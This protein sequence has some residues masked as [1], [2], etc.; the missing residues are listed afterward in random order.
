MHVRCGVKGVAQGR[1]AELAHVA[2]L[3][4][5]EV[6]AQVVLAVAVQLLGHPL[7]VQLVAERDLLEPAVRPVLVRRHAQVVVLLVAQQRPVVAFRAVRLA[8]EQRH[9]ALLL[10]AEGVLRAAHVAVEGGIVGDQRAL[11]RG[12]GAP[13]V[14]DGRPLVAEHP[15]EP[16]AVLGHQAQAGFHDLAFAIARHGAA[17]RGAGLGFQGLGRAGPEQLAQVGGVDHALAV[18]PVH[19][20]GIPAAQRRGEGPAGV[21]F[22]TI[23][24]GNGGIAAEAGVE[25][26]HLAQFHLGGGLLVVRRDGRIAQCFQRRIHVR[27]APGT[28]GLRARPHQQQGRQQNVQCGRVGVHEVSSWLRPVAG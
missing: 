18:A 16:S 25:E 21:R 23:R 17:R 13:G 22:M 24:A 14:A 11:E 27:I 1:R 3:L 28:G 26:E 12:D 7:G 9:A 15:V 20:R 5:A 4:G 6:Q 10:V 19:R 2:A 8:R